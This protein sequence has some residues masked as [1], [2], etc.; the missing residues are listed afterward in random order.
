MQVIMSGRRSGK[1]TR[2]IRY[3]SDNGIT[4]VCINEREAKRVKAVA[5]SMFELGQINNM[6]P[7]PISI[8]EV[9]GHNSSRGYIFD[10]VN[11]WLKTKFNGQLI[12]VTWDVDY[13]HD[14][15]DIEEEKHDFHI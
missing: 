4:I 3:A 6:I 9:D 5:K 15:I 11:I 8:Y 14:Y 7:D 10:N 12:G 2:C 13:K 1:T